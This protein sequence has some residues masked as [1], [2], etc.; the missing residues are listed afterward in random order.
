MPS[1]QIINHSSQLSPQAKGKPLWENI[2][3]EAE[4]FQK[5]VYHV[6]NQRIPSLIPK[7]SKFQLPN[8]PLTLPLSPPGRGKGE[9]FGILVIG[10][11]LGFGV[12]NLLLVLFF[13]FIGERFVDQHHRDIIL[14]GIEQAT[15]FADQA[16]PFSIQKNIPLTFR[17]G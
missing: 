5:Y 14:N 17:T 13:S 1:I 15:G 8:A 11:Y 16:I 9:G 6:S 12:S 10:I 3:E 2:D 7:S 4:S